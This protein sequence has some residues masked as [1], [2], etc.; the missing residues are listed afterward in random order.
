MVLWDVI[1]CSLVHNDLKKPA[2]LKM[3]TVGSSKCRYL[4][5]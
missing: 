3:E 4:S 1:P 5:T 2:A